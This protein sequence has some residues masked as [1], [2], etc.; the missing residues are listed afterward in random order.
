MQY[1][2][3]KFS[4]LAISIIFTKTFRW[5]RSSMYTIFKY[6]LCID[7]P[8]L[9]FFCLPECSEFTSTC[10][11]EETNLIKGLSLSHLSVSYSPQKTEF[12]WIRKE[13][14]WKKAEEMRKACGR[15]GTRW[16]ISFPYQPCRRFQSR[17]GRPLQ[18]SRAA[19]PQYK[20]LYKLCALLHCQMVALRHV[21]TPPKKCIL[22]RVSSITRG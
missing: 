17:L 12:R 4:F 8:C 19:S 14:D 20:R 15:G 13:V 3:F 16:P 18:P 7:F 5:N 11:V 1:F 22:P 21:K 9:I 6:Y 2:F 10:A